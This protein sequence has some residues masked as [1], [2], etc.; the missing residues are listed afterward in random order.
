[1]SNFRPLNRYT[2]GTI[3]FT[4]EGEQFLV[5]RKAL[6]LAQDSGDTYIT[7]TE[8]MIKRPDMI[9]YNAYKT[10]DL[11]WVIMEYN[12]V[13]DPFFDLRINQMLR[14]PK[15]ERVLDAINKMNKV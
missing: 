2:N 4:R 13:S 11:W 9:S 10:P 7:L 3:T 14:I 12:N 5:L 6:N 1:M 15:I 8:D